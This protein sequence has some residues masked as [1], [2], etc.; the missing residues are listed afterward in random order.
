MRVSGRS[1]SPP[2]RPRGLRLVALLEGKGRDVDVG[3]LDD[4]PLAADLARSD[5]RPR[6]SDDEPY[7][8]RSQ[9]GPQAQFS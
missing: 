5:R 6:H 3:A 1:S 7:K 9:R 2:S 4:A 8:Q